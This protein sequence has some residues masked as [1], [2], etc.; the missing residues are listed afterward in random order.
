MSIDELVRRCEERLNHTSNPSLPPEE[1]LKAILELDKE[2]WNRVNESES[3]KKDLANLQNE[4][5]ELGIQNAKLTARVDELLKKSEEQ[6]WIATELGEFVRN[7]ANRQFV[8]N[9]P[10]AARRVYDLNKDSIV[11]P[12]LNAFLFESEKDA[13]EAYRAYC[14]ENGVEFSEANMLRWLFDVVRR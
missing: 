11:K 10:A 13:H 3:L 12:F 8:G 1:T 14:T 7:V 2:R 9:E 4:L 6:A 5:S